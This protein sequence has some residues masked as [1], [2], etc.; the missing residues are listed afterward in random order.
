MDD[1]DLG[2]D[3]AVGLIAEAVVAAAFIVAVLFVG[4]AL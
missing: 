3:L 2:F 4:M 1:F